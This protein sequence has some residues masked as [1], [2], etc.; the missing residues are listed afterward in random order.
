MMSTT[1]ETMKEELK[2]KEDEL[3][4]AES[5]LAGR[6]PLAISSQ[7][8]SSDAEGKNNRDGILKQS[9]FLGIN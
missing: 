3:Q 8:S 7:L 4:L 5:R 1:L 2:T 6:G 9:R